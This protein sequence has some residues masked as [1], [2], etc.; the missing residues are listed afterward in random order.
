[1][2]ANILRAVIDKGNTRIK[3]AIFENSLLKDIFFL[4]SSNEIQS[5]LEKYSISSVISTIPIEIEPTTNYHLLSNNSVLPFE[6]L[7][8]SPATLGLDR[9]AS[10]AQASKHF[11]NQNTLVI[12]AGTC[13]T[14]DILEASNKYLGGNIAP[15]LTMRW[16]AMNKFTSS[17]PLG[18]L[19][20]FSPLLGNNTLSAISNGAIQG[21]IYE[22][23]GYIDV[24]NKKY[25]NL[26]IV[27]TGGD[28]KYLAKQ[29]NYRIFA[30]DEWV[31]Q[32]LFQL[33]LLNEI[34]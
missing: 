33:L 28:A 8:K 22:I 2:K 4:T 12:D 7:Y 26:N 27:L 1:M 32:G 30:N 6:N 21:V 11:H 25:E 13:I 19:S 20:D 14:Y 17:L 31:L 23:S 34:K 18:Q 3:I 9:I 16:Q 10:M 24:L 15:G 29:L 5:Y